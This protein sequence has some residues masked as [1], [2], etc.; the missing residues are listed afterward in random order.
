MS[1]I[2]YDKNVFDNAGYVAIADDPDKPLLPAD[3]GLG[4]LVFHV[5][6][7]KPGRQIWVKHRP[8]GDGNTP[9]TAKAALTEVLQAGF[10]QV[11]AMDREAL[12]DAHISAS[13]YIKALE[14]RNAQA[15]GSPAYAAA[16][17]EMDAHE[18]L[19][20]QKMAF[21]CSQLYE[22]SLGHDFSMSW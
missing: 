13:L 2:E 18:L 3:R 19:Y 6:Y 17:A 11:E 1:K 7:T 22:D 8:Y 14:A 20:K 12:I 16:Q 5:T 4:F 15:E 10:P 21:I 9:A